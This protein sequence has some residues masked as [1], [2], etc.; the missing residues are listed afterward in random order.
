MTA[1]YSLAGILQV[2]KEMAA[3]TKAATTASTKSPTTKEKPMA[4][5][6]DQ[7]ENDRRRP[8]RCAIPTSAAG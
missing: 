5:E 1:R 8:R 6:G 7:G 2:L 4:T 3:A